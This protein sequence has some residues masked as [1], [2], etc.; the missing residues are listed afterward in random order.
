MTGRSGPM[1]KQTNSDYFLWKRIKAGETQSFHD[2]YMRYADTLFSF[3]KIFTKDQELVKDCIHD[4]ILDLYKYRKGLSENDNIRNYLFKALK[5]KIQGNRLKKVDLLYTENFYR[6][7]GEK[8]GPDADDE[9]EEQHEKLDRIM[10]LIDRL[11]EK[12]REILHLRFQIELSYEEIAQVMDISVESVRTSVYR[13]VKS[14]REDLQVKSI[15]L[16]FVTMK[17]RAGKFTSS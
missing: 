14:L 2:L 1:G 6:E 16:L 11:P 4:L 3:G 9:L 7:A 17:M 12:Q 13:S 5:R 8:A 10:R 15:Y